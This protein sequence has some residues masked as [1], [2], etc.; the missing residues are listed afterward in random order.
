MTEVVASGEQVDIVVSAPTVID[1]VASAP[2]IDVFVGAS[3][4]GP[5]GPQGPQGATGATGPKGDTGATGAT[6]AKGDKGDQGIQGIQGIQ[7]V[8]GDTGATGAKGDTGATGP[9][10]P[11]GDTGNTG[12]TGAGYSGVTSTSTITIGSGLK[13]FTLVGSN[14][15]AFVTGMRVRAI[16]TDTPTYYMEGPANYIGGGTL[17][18]TVDKSNG[19]GSHNSWNFSV[20]GEI[21][22]TGATG[23][24]GSSGVV[25]VIAPI[26]N[27]GTSTAANIGIDQTGITIAQSQVTN[28]TTALAGKA[29]L[30]ASQTFTGAQIITG[31]S[32]TDVPLTVKRYNA[33]ATADLFNVTNDVGSSFFKVGYNGAITFSGNNPMTISSQLNVNNRLIAYSGTLGNQNPNEY[34]PLKIT[35]NEGS[36]TTPNIFEAWQNSARGGNLSCYIS[37]NGYLYARIGSSETPQNLSDAIAAKLAGN[38]AHLSKHQPLTA[39]DTV[40]RNFASGS[41]APGLSTNAFV[42]FTPLINLTV[43]QISMATAGTASS[44]LTLARM[45]LYTFDGTTMTLVARTANDTTLFNAAHTVFTRSFNTTGGY[46]STYTLVAGERYAVGVCQTGSTAANFRALAHQTL[47]ELMLQNLSPRITGIKTAQTDLVTTNTTFNNT[48]AYTLFARLS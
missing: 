35:G 41:G 47:Q 34:P 2:A 39:L 22:A 20:A 15:G 45:G 25:S 23:A 30:T 18:I 12:A 36:E 13:T 16:H 1:I 17:I 31:G 43:S 40:E 4:A 9:Q 48:T 28:L 42:F 11:K 10:G 38:T 7:G 6:G 3:V 5:V 19:S 29:A 26:T 24:T 37:E 14:Q 44:G 21:G 27:S 33:F 46:P 32:T 8:K